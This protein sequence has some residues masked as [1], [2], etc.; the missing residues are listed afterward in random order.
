MKKRLSILIFVITISLLASSSSVQTAPP[1]LQIAVYPFDAVGVEKTVATYVTNAV[2]RLLGE[3]DK[4]VVRDQFSTQAAI[5]QIGLAQSGHC[6]EDSCRVEAGKILKA[7]KLVMGTVEKPEENYFT[8]SLRVVDVQTARIEY[9]IA[10]DCRCSNVPQVRDMAVEL[11]RKTILIYLETG[12][13]PQPASGNVTPQPPTE[14]VTPPPTEGYGPEVA[15]VPRTAG[16]GALIVTTSP[17]GADIYLDATLVGKTPKTIANVAAGT[18]QLTLVLDGYT[19]LNKG[20]E[21]RA[22]GSVVVY[23]ILVRQTGSIEVSSTPAGA[24]IWMDNKYVGVAPKKLPGMPVGKHTVR[25]SLPDYQ[26]FSREV[27]VEINGTAEVNAQLAGLPGRI[28]VTSIPSGAEVFIDGRKVGVTPYSSQVPPGDH[29]VQVAAQGYQSAEETVSILPNKAKTLD[30]SLKK[31][32]SLD[33]SASRYNRIAAGALHTCALTSSGGVK[34]WGRNNF[35]QLGNG[36][37]SETPSTRPVDV[38]GMTSG[39]VSLTAGFAHSCA[40]NS[41]GGVKCWGVNYTLGGNSPET[42]YT[43][44]DVTGLTSG[45]V[46]IASGNWHT[47]AL[48]TSGGIKCWATNDHGELG[49]GTKE[50]R[51]KPVDVSGL[52]SG[53][54]AIDAGYEHTCAL[55]TTGKVKCWGMNLYGQLGD[56][57][58]TDQYYPTDV[59]IPLGKVVSIYLDQN[60][61]TAIT[62]EGA[63]KCWGQ[64]PNDLNDISGNFVAVAPANDHVCALTSSG[65]VKCWG[66]NLYG[67]LGGSIGESYTNSIVDVLGLTSGVVEITSGWWHT[68]ALTSS[69]QVK[70]WGKNGDGALG[71]G[72]TT[73]RRSPMDVRW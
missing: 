27:T 69:G 26:D 62:A 37:T 43:P 15:P 36:T 18:H 58:K 6:T 70:C 16:E 60:Y 45:V 40:L 19:N 57:S 17:P 20:V 53:V 28:L 9:Q 64:C 71:D 56:G 4:L 35:G 47:C 14:P 46:M 29:S 1:P 3:S 61:S 66:S 63:I 55:M 8:V 72:S 38:V 67:N 48:I 21:V 11:A 50:T 7:Q 39:Y 10:Q 31:G 13:K 34:C 33:V 5:E 2:F 25:L 12:K 49:D 30:I 22:G 73:D 54:V 42:P 44:V 52:S 23:E 68:C 51:Y 24:G 59:T 41:T 32:V 65:G